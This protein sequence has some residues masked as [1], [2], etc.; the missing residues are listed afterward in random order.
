MPQI[1]NVNPAGV[2]KDGYF[3][4]MTGIVWLLIGKAFDN[5]FMT[6]TETKATTLLPQSLMSLVNFRLPQNIG[7]VRPTAGSFLSC[8]PSNMGC[9]VSR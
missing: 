3:A 4:E 2:N 9:A 8:I 1:E 6:T 7:Q 5:T